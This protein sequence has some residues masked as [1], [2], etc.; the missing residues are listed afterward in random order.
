MVIKQHNQ[1]VNLFEKKKSKTKKNVF[2]VTRNR[3][4]RSTHFT[5][6][7]TSR[8][9]R[10]Y[11][12]KGTRC[13]VDVHRRNRERE[14]V[15]DHIR[16][17][18]QNVQDTQKSERSPR[19]ARLQERLSSFYLELRGRSLAPGKPGVLERASPGRRL[20]S[21]PTPSVSL[22]PSLRCRGKSP[23]R[24]RPGRGRRATEEEEV[25]RAEGGER[26]P[27]GPSFLPSFLPPS[28]HS[29][30][31][32]FVAPFGLRFLVLVAPSSLRCRRATSSWRVSTRLD[33]HCVLWLVII[34]NTCTCHK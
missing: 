16:G 3:W 14:T 26:Q 9:R 15:P 33:C 18:M 29:L 2:A 24:W 6:S 1:D 12:H 5:V 25:E 19:K 8:R 23:R 17:F 20:G 10:D 22:A 7:S 30:R 28:F 13:C 32:F 34:Y 27:C 4:K 11:P 31:P 21:I